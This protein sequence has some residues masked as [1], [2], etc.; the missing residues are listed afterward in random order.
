MHRMPLLNL[1]LWLLE[2]GKKNLKRQAAELKGQVT[3]IAGPNATGQ[4]ADLEARLIQPP[5]VVVQGLVRGAPT[6]DVTQAGGLG[7][8][9]EIVAAGPALETSTGAPPPPAAVAATSRTVMPPQCPQTLWLGRST[10]E[11][12]LT[13]CSLVALFN[14][15]DCPSVGRDLFIYLSCAVRDGSPMWGMSWHG[16]NGS[17]SK[18]SPS[19][20]RKLV[21][22]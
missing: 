18:S 22:P 1:K 15:K 3:S 5:N 2:Q 10:V 6:H 21:F 20:D 11:R 19:L 12:S 7:A 17:R 14:L 13:S 8:A 4:E 16:V 9:A